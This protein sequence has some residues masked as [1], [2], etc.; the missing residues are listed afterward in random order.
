MLKP[1]LT[2]G[3]MRSL[4]KVSPIENSSELDVMKKKIPMQST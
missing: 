4:K 3:I 2:K 1:W